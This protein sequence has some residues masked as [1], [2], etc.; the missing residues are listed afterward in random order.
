MNNRRRQLT[1]GPSLGVLI[2]ES[3]TSGITNIQL[4]YSMAGLRHNVSAGLLVL[5]IGEA[6]EKDVG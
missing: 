4:D 2:T 6:A 1:A 3:G 5:A